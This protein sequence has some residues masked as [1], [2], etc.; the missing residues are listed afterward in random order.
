MVRPQSEF[1]QEERR[2]LRLVAEARTNA[3]IQRILQI[4]PHELA[5]TLQSVY[6]KTGIFHPGESWNPHEMRARLR[7]WGQHYFAGEGRR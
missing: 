1:T 2:V 7:Q 5:K 6:L 4:T 3:T